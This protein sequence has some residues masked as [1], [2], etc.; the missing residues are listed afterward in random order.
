MR[1]LEQVFTF[2]GFSFPKYVWTLPRRPRSTSTGEYYHAPTPNAAKTAGFYLDS[3]GMPG[4]RWTWCDEVAAARIKHTGWY[5]DEHGDRELIRG[6]V[7]RLPQFRGFLA[8]WSMGKGMASSLDVSKIY[9]TETEAAYAS[10][11]LAQNTAEQEQEFQEAEQRRIDAEEKREEIKKALE[12]VRH[13][14]TQHT[15]AIVTDA[16]ERA[17]SVARSYRMQVRQLAHLKH[18]EINEMREELKQ[19]EEG[20]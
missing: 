12:L 17:V 8:G 13:Y 10:D 4:L 9:E 11:A 6:I 18:I 5:S 7:V 14:R 15:L 2:A 1:A 19:L 16:P 3:D 20:N